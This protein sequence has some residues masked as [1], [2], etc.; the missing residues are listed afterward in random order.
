MI[1]TQ[2]R[3]TSNFFHASA[4]KS[5]IIMI[6]MSPQR[7][8]NTKNSTS[9]YSH[10]KTHPTHTVLHSARCHACL[11][12]CTANFEKCNSKIFENALQ[13]CMNSGASATKSLQTNL[14]NCSFNISNITLACN[15]N[16]H[17]YKIMTAKLHDL[18]PSIKRNRNV[19]P[20]QTVS[21]HQRREKYHKKTK[22]IDRCSARERTTCPGWLRQVE[23]FAAV[24]F[25]VFS[26]V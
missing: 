10:K 3:F 2:K 15:M 13:T 7:M 20:L 5:N 23:V 12:K 26:V 16:C 6:P 9:P 25:G 18:P 19:A 11:K 21:S 4:S 22:F 17:P 14:A 24:P 1:S 8:P